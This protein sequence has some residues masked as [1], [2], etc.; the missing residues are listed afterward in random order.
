[1]QCTNEISRKEV[2]R[3][4]HELQTRDVSNRILIQNTFKP[5]TLN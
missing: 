1:M 5:G 2:R 4:P 3:T